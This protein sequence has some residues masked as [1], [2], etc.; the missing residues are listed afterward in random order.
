MI[1]LR[2]I[3][4]IVD[5]SYRYKMQPVDMVKQKSIYVIKNINQIAKNI[6][7]DPK[8]IIEFLK[9]KLGVQINYNNELNSAEVKNVSH[10]Q[11]QK[12]I[13]EF[14]Q[15]YVLCPTCC[16][17]ETVLSKTILSKKNSCVFI[18]CKACSHYDRIKTDNKIVSKTVN[19]IMKLL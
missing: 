5:P 7:R 16:N 2:G 18:K 3:N 4:D 12:S 19:N 9:K 14:I 13:Y 11:V 8:M 1:N 15:Y 6:D 17:P 10:D